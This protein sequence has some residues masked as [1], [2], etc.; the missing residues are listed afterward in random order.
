MCVLSTS[1]A[2]PPAPACRYRLSAGT[3][4]GSWP[5]NSTPDARCWPP[6]GAWQQERSKKQRP[7]RGSRGYFFWGR[8]FCFLG[9]LVRITGSKK[10]PPTNNKTPPTA[11]A[12]KNNWLCG[13]FGLCPT[14]AYH[15]GGAPSAICF[16]RA[17]CAAPR[18]PIPTRCSA[19][20]Y[21][22]LAQRPSCGF[23]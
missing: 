15:V 18:S 19:A 2:L 7:A 22:L 9:F 13:L 20:T 12:P 21:M 5:P 10:T 16:R 23:I 1:P 8:V 14:C 4:S 17:L 6:L 3:T 11:S